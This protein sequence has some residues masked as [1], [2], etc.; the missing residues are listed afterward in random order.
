MVEPDARDHAADRRAD[1]G[2]IQPSAQSHLQHHGIDLL[3]GEV[4]KPNRRHHLKE[5]GYIRGRRVFARFAIHFG[6]HPRQSIRQVDQ[7]RLADRLTVNLYPFL[8][9]QQM[10]RGE[11]AGAKP[12]AISML[13]SMLDV[14]PLP[15]LP[16]M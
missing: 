15:L 4:K 1:I 9:S 12:H 13:A 7:F 11:Q 3:F 16:V 2:R 10:R 8:K 14:E 5:C 6:N